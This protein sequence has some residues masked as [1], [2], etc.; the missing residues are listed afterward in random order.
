MKRNTLFITCIVLGMASCSNMQSNSE[1]DTT[2][3]KI[4]T[5]NK[6]TIYEENAVVEDSF[7]SP[8]RGAISV[9]SVPNASSSPTSWFVKTKNKCKICKSGNGCSGYWG[10]YHSNG[11]YEGTC[12]N[13]DGWGHRC[14][15][16][17]EKHGLRRW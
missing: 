5:M 8:V 2:S 10:I 1:K 13:S 6:Q 9:Q 11:T 3:E 14:G 15:H 17:P 4:E 7:D 12:Q 16:G